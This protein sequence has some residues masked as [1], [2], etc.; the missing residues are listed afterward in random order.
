VSER[1]RERGRGRE[2]RKEMRILYKMMKKS[3]KNWKRDRYLGGK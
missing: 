3:K 1:E 2:G